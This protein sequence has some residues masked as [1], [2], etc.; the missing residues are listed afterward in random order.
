MKANE[1]QIE[2][3]VFSPSGRVHKMH[4][5]EFSN[6]DAWFE[7]L[8]P[9][10][11]TPEILEKNGFV[12]D[13]S[14]DECIADY[15]YVTVQ[16]WRYHGENVLIDWDGRETRIDND[17]GIPCESIHLIDA[18]VHELQHALRLCGLNEL[19]DNFTI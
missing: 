6:D 11:L 17:L 18:K 19:A 2:D 3:F 10:P 15:C 9:I 13:A 12:N 7:S 16:L 14:Y 8:T 5:V 4:R 1:L